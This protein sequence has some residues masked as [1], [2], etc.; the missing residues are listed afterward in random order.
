[1]WLYGLLGAFA[2]EL[3]PGLL[4][5]I[6]LGILSAIPF[7]IPL[8]ILPGIPPGISL[9]MSPAT[10]SRLPQG[11]LYKILQEVY[12]GFHQKFPLGFDLELFLDSQRGFIWDS[13]RIFRIPMVNPS[14]ITLA[15]AFRISPEISTGIS[16]GIPGPSRSFKIFSRN[17]FRDSSENTFV[18]EIVQRFLHIFFWDSSKN[19]SWDSSRS[20]F[21]DSSKNL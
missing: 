13:S 17:L 10:L 3:L 6:F 1:M 8:G 19:S 12:L 7:S 2:Q 5:R 20:S 11:A 16:S 15:I 9:L 14:G 21:R 4:S 18:Q